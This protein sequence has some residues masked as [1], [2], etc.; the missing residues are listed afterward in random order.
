MRTV[1]RY[2]IAALVGVLLLGW[3]W[4]FR[5][6]YVALVFDK[7]T[8]QQLEVK[9]LPDVA[10]NEFGLVA[11]GHVLDLALPDKKAVAA[12]AQPDANGHL[13]LVD[14]AS[15]ILL[16][17]RTKRVI[18]NDETVKPAFVYALEP[19]DRI[20]LSMNRGWLAWPTFFETNFMTG[21][22]TLWRRYK[23]YLFT[24]RK[25]SGLSVD[26]LWRYQEFYYASDHAWVAGD[27][28]CE[29]N[30]PPCGLIRVD[31]RRGG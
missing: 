24:L 26:M 11:G 28:L 12:T 3:A 23:Y 9:A 14:G 16:G 4:L 31:V 8:T 15:H 7:L 13:V 1:L 27:R 30:E 21:N 6:Q 18:N 17:R 22:V 5:M 2:A 20:F 29:A 25:A 10:W 19:G